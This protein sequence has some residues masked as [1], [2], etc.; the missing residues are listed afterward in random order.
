MRWGLCQEGV[1]MYL[2]E[3]ENCI[4]ASQNSGLRRFAMLI[5]GFVKMPAKTCAF[6]FLCHFTFFFSFSL[7]SPKISHAD[8]QMF[9]GQIHS[10]GAES[11]INWSFTSS[12]RH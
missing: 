12:P 9:L 2:L 1:G 5:V 6:C 7:I 10:P 11:T 4:F 3:R 8:G